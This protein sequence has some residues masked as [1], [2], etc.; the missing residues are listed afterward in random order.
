MQALISARR[1]AAGRRAR[2]ILFI[3]LL[4]YLLAVTQ[5]V[6]LTWA[7]PPMPDRAAMTQA[8]CVRVSDGDTAWFEVPGAQVQQVRF[9]N[10]DAPESV[11]PDLPPQ[12]YGAEASAFTRQHLQGKTVWLEDD[13]RHFDAHG[14]RLRHVW[15]EDGSLFGLTLVAQGYAR[16]MVIPPNTRYEDDFVAAEVI[17]KSEGAWGIAGK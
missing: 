8:V 3:V 6:P 10:I 2:R 4:V 17:A 11:H 13:I 5:P 14:R 15:L 1:E 16:V 12:P 7:Y 9:L